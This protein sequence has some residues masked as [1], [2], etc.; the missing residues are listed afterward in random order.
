M[1]LTFSFFIANDSILK[2]QCSLQPDVNITKEITF[3]NP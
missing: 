3:L 1:K 2:L